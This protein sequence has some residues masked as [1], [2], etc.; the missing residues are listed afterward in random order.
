MASLSLG[1]MHI[2]PIPSLIVLLT[3]WNLSSSPNKFLPVRLTE[4]AHTDAQ[5]KILG[6]YLWG[7]L[8]VQAD[9]H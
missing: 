3:P 8:G 2:R 1:V 4:S 7:V 5:E 6:Q 9:T